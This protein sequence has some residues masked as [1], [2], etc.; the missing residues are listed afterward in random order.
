[1]GLPTN[2]YT[3]AHTHIQTHTHIHTTGPHRRETTVFATRS[4]LHVLFRHIC[5]TRARAFVWVF[6]SRVLGPRICIYILSCMRCVCIA[7]IL[8]S[9]DGGAR[10]LCP[11]EPSRRC[12]TVS[13][14]RQLY[15]IACAGVY[16]RACVYRKR[17]DSLPA[18]RALTLATTAQLG[19]HGCGAA[20]HRVC[21]YVSD[22]M[23]AAAWVDV[24]C[25]RCGWWT[26]KTGA[27][28]G[29]TTLAA[30]CMSCKLN[31]YEYIYIYA[32]YVW[33]KYIYSRR[34]DARA[35]LGQLRRVY[36]M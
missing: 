34:S 21:V 26:R 9:I 5:R 20:A 15:D 10:I 35:M 32:I 2:R 16:V 13:S 4:S 33:I 18:R 36:M 31:M 24:K 30:I 27:Q 12:S 19:D 23:W 29:Y 1:M 7:N 11:R 17:A 25:A 14:S 6:A 3:H 8:E 28:D 22:H